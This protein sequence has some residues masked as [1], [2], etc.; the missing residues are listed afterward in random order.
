MSSVQN[1]T[2]YIAYFSNASSLLDS[3]VYSYL[4]D[5]NSGF[6]VQTKKS[7]GHHDLILPRSLRLVRSSSFQIVDAGSQHRLRQGVSQAAFTRYLSL[8]LSTYSHLRRC[9]TGAYISNLTGELSVTCGSG[10]FNLCDQPF[11]T[12]AY[13]TI[14]L[15]ILRTY[16]V[17]GQNSLILGVGLC[18]SLGR[19][20]IA[21]Y[22]CHSYTA[23]QSYPI[24]ICDNILVL[25]ILGRLGSINL[26]S[27]QPI[28]I[29]ST[30]K[31]MCWVYN[32]QRQFPLLTV[33]H[34]HF[35]VMLTDIF[36]LL[37]VG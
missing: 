29:T 28:N 5:G 34:F 24:L 35:W 2:T 23:Q 15:L 4:A 30:S 19:A 31:S 18:I 21:I 14:A 3:W 26:H 36:L 27:I 13:C 20:I 22:V 11:S 1:L 9:T 12:E 25:M 6:L 37:G 32:W 33:R 17:C 8:S 16:A 7:Y 10:T